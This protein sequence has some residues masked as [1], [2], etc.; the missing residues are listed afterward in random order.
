[1]QSRVARAGLL[2]LTLGLNLAVWYGVGRL[3]EWR[4]GL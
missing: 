3:M 2:A 1:M 4:I